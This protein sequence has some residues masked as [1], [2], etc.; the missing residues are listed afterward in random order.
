MRIG[1]IFPQTEFG[2]DPVA[3]RDYAQTVEGLGFA[4]LLAFDHVMGANPQRVGRVQLLPS[5]A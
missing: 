4:H 2:N 3:M 1:V 5:V